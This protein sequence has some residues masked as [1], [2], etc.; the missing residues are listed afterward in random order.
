M[1]H[2]GMTKFASASARALDWIKRYIQSQGGA[3]NCVSSMAYMLP[4]VLN[5]AGM[6]VE[7]ELALAKCIELTI[8][9]RDSNKSSLEANFPLNARAW[10]T[11]TAQSMGRFEYAFSLM[12]DLRNYYNPELGGFM[13]QDVYKQGS[14]SDVY[15]TSLIGHVSLY[16]GDLNK[17]IRAGN[18]VLRCLAMQPDLKRSFYLH[19]WE[20]GRFVT[21]FT[22]EN[23][24][25]YLLNLQKSGEQSYF[26]LGLPILFLTHLYNVT[27][28][29]T[30]YSGA[31]AYLEI[32]K[33]CLKH[34]ISGATIGY[35]P[36]SLVTL[37]SVNKP[38]NAANLQQLF[39]ESTDDWLMVQNDY[40]G[41]SCISSEVDFHAMLNFAFGNKAVL[42]ELGR[43]S[44]LRDGT[45]HS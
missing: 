11:L 34:A 12:N 31:L 37:M 10:L 15:T 39:L 45:V 36:I 18:F 28:D 22:P 38:G 17:A 24:D 21:D 6:T 13:T 43:A 14:S 32:V 5:Q 25:Y 4:L 41:G 30:Y 8:N 35:I 1:L 7:A 19:M 26:L 3:E 44:V 9:C 23:S 16:F 29:D 2:E 20:D 42:A 33:S 40:I 27:G